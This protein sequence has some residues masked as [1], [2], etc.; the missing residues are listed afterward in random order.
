MC[1]P[2]VYRENEVAGNKVLEEALSGMF[3][4]YLKDGPRAKQG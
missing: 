2:E 3:W 1:K 4:N